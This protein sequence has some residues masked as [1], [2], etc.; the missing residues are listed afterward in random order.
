M[1]ECQKI[2][3]IRL[4]AWSALSN[5]ETGLCD[6]SLSK[7]SDHNDRL[8]TLNFNLGKRLM[9]P[10]VEKCRDPQSAGVRRSE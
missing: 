1:K 6:R 9:N 10:L 5:R 4:D 2:D 8:N 3:R 7:R